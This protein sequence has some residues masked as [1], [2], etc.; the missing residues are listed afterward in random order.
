[1]AIVIAEPRIQFSNLMAIIS[2]H[3]TILKHGYVLS[4]KQYRNDVFMCIG[5]GS[6]A[7]YKKD[8]LYVFLINAFYYFYICMCAYEAGDRE[9]E[10]L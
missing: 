9:E 5:M 6:I 7:E 1:M 2:P 8:V 3:H 10:T 4:W